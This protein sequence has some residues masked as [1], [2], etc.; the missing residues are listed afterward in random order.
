MVELER[1]GVIREGMAAPPK[2]II[3]QSEQQVYLTDFG[4]K[5]EG[6]GLVAEVDTKVIGA[7]WVRIM[8]D[9][10]HVDDATPSFAI[11]L[12][13]EFRGLGTGT[14]P[15]KEMLC[16]LKQRGYLYVKCTEENVFSKVIAYMQE[17]GRGYMFFPIRRL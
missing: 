12:Y 7:V 10:G 16:I 2:S 3:G 5:K 9:Y 11:S 8:N 13:K 1:P 6:V 14:S 15:M 4:K 17:S